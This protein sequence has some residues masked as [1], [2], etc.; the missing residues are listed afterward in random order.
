MCAKSREK[1]TFDYL[2]IRCPSRS[3]NKIDG[4]RN[5][6]SFA[7]RTIEQPYVQLVWRLDRGFPNSLESIS[8]S[9][10]PIAHV[11]FFFS[12]P[13]VYFHNTKIELKDHRECVGNRKEKRIEQKIHPNKKLAHTIS[14]NVFALNLFCL[15]CCCC[16]EKHRNNITAN[17]ILNKLWTNLECMLFY[18]FAQTK[19]TS[20]IE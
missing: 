20:N 2:W 5:V 6:N 1:F 17:Q 8:I 10:L 13:S 15:F 7:N 12:I 16:C 11:H 3:T 9:A 14:F 19:I 4:Q 18:R